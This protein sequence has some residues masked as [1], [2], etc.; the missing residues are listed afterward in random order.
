M[1]ALSGIDLSH[2][3]ITDISPVA[4]IN[5][6]ENSVFLLDL[7][8]N[9]IDKIVLNESARYKKL[10]IY[11]NPISD[12]GSLYTINYSYI[13][14]SY[15]TDIDYDKLAQLSFLECNMT[16]CP[17]DQQVHIEEVL[18]SYRLKLI[19]QKEADE[20]TASVKPSFYGFS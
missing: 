12:Y 17:L 8:H 11:D 4:G 14:F 9:K 3:E 18:G 15:S 19:T 20:Y 6:Y 1:K 13:Y 7:S 2:N 5:G 10:Y 16:D